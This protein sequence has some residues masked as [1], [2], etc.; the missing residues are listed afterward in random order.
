MDFVWVEGGCYNMGSEDGRWDEEPI[1]EVC[2]EGFWIG[3]HEVTQGQW[4]QYMGF[5]PSLFRGNQNPVDSVSWVNAKKYATKLGNSGKRRFRLP[6]EAEWEF[7]ARS[8]REG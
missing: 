2:V 4:G 1:H 8:Q 6:T 5:N 7:A 3:R